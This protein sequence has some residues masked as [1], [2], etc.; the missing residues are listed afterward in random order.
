MALRFDIVI[1]QGSDYGVAFPVL[2][3]GGQ[4]PQDLTGWTVRCQARRTATDTSA[5]HDFAD[6]LSLAGSDAVLSVPGSVSASWAWTSAL[7]DLKV[8]APGGAPTRLVE[9]HLTVR[10]AVTR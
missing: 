3:P 1:D 2:E 6:E 7:Y 9:G 4:E 5:L 10:P 8:V